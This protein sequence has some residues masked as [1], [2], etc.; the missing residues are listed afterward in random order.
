LPTNILHAFFV[1]LKQATRPNYLIV[2]HSARTTNHDH[3]TIFSSHGICNCLILL[4]ILRNFFL[5]RFQLWVKQYKKKRLLN[6][7][8][9]VSVQLCQPKPAKAIRTFMG[10]RHSAL[11]VLVCLSLVPVISIS[12][13]KAF[14]LIVL[15]TRHEHL[16]MQS[17]N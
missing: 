14:A 13:A 2:L 10:L 15:Y 4:R 9:V 17:F 11:E 3:Y 7:V 1:T 16:T 12:I 6:G 5:V 8:F